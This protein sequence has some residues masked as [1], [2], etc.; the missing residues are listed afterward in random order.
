MEFALY[1]MDDENDR[2]PVFL[3]CKRMLLTPAHGFRT[4]V[5]ASYNIE[6]RLLTLC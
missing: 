1:V 2:N 3:G 5:A 4:W 6:L